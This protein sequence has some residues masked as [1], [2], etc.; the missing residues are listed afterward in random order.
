M[1]DFRNQI[2]HEYF[3][4]D[5]DVVWTIIYVDLIPFEEVIIELIDSIEQDLKDELIS[6]YIEDNSYL[7]FIVNSLK[8]LK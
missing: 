4:I 5:Q 1:V 3:G 7:D 2:T 6:T 8:E